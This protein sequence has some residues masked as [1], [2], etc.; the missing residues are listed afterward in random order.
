MLQNIHW[1]GH[2]SFLIKKE[3]IIY[4]DPFK[5]KNIEKKEKADLILITHDHFDHFSLDDINKIRK[6]ST[7]IIAPEELRGKING[8]LKLLKPFQNIEIDNIKI[9][10]VPAYNVNKFR[11]PGKVFH[12][13]EDN[14]LGFIIKTDNKK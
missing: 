5:I 13:R 14:K 4:I 6:N 3:K 11:A 1:L 12:P 10:A 9:E 8:S 7:I 2:D